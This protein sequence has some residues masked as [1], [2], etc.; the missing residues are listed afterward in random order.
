[1]VTASDVASLAA[2][3][4]ATV[5]RVLNPETRRLVREETAHRVLQAAGT[6]GYRPNQ[7]ARAVRTSRSKSIGVV[8]RDIA[9]PLCPLIVR[10]IEDRVEAE[11]YILLLMN[12][13]DDPAREQLAFEALLA[14]RV[15]GFITAIVPAG[16]PLPDIAAAGLPVV[17]VNRR[18]PNR[19]LPAVVVDDDVGVR[20]A[21]SHLVRLGHRRIAHVAA[22]EDTAT[23]GGRRT[24]FLR[25]V[26]EAGLEP[27]PR[28]VVTGS[29]F[30]EEESARACTTLLD[31]DAGWT[32]VVAATDVAA[33]GC[34]AALR[35]RGCEIPGNVSVVGFNDMPFSD[36]F[37]PPLTTVR[38]PH[39]QIG[40]AAAELLLERLR[41][42]SARRQIVLA[43]SLVARGSTAMR[44]RR[45]ASASMFEKSP[46]KPTNEP[47]DLYQPATI[48]P[49]SPR[50]GFRSRPR[51]RSEIA[52]FAD[53]GGD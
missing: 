32:G 30:D 26:R 44:C 25:A 36:R 22:C 21:V 19:S 29:A 23:G 33:A 34:Y 14:R 40:R 31:R 51:E 2:V 45:L 18:L 50:S 52:G 41:G 28:L 43:P 8:V 10:G 4:R 47:N 46:A 35:E 9:D 27:D 7:I 12:T 39:Y 48:V 13:D 16:R 3:H 6:L 20:M 37:D 38:V 1:M 5:S 49:R 24:A 15:D 11:G 17:L 53:T 42:Q